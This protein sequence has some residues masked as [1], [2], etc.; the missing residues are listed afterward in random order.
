MP[1]PVVPAVA[2][3]TPA[4]PAPS[5]HDKLQAKVAELLKPPVVV[6]AKKPDPAVDMDPETLRRLTETSERAR[7]EKKRADD[8][9]AREKDLGGAEVVALREAQK[10]WKEG[11]QAGA[12]AKLAAVEDPDAEI[13]KLLNGWLKKPKPGE[14]KL[15][16]DEIKALQDEA[17]ASK[18]DREAREVS[19]KQQAQRE[20][21]QKEADRLNA[22]TRDLKA[23]D[24]KTL[25]FP[26]AAAASEESAVVAME[27]ANKLM[28]K[29]KIDPK[30]LTRE[31]A[32]DLFERA[33]VEI[34]ANLAKLAA[35]EK[36]K[37]EPKPLVPFSSPLRVQR[38]GVDPARTGEY[39]KNLM[40]AASQKLRERA[41]AAGIIP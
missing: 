24:G 33:Y 9:E 4:I 37:A 18:A 21:G 10:L 12:I 32:E 22:T 3:E 17:A 6:E 19:A 7:R 5:A 36:A 15:T 28:V 39:S 35:A 27:K 30:S 1:D 16:P 8:A 29:L 31:L 14:P 11:D 2:A 23:E 41:R 20:A 13:E 25:R 34:E 38:A 26:L 40:D